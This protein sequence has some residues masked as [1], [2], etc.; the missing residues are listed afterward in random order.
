MSGFE[1]RNSDAESLKFRLR[2]WVVALVVLLMFGL[3]VFRLFTLQVVRHDAFAE[4]AESNRTAVVPIVPNRGQILDRNG[5]VLATNYS[6]YT[7]EITRSKVNDLEDTITQLSE[8]VDI[9]PRDRRKFKRLMEDSKRFE[10][11]PIR[12][13]LTDEEVARFAAQRWRFPGVDIKARFFRSYP[14]EDV[15][16]H[17]VGY[18]G[19]INQKEQEALEDS[20][21]AANYRGTEVIGK[22]GIEQSYEKQLHGTTGWEQLET[23]AGGFAVRRLN[24]RPAT[25][26]DSVVLSLDIGLQKLVEDLFGERRGALVAMDPR[27]GEVLAMVSKPGYDVNLFVDGIDQE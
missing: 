10:S 16:G 17:V 8:L 4:R 27:N 23:T 18:I 6:A 15:G 24:S 12:S 7:L 20:D 26:G 5:I 19:R 21:D 25:A 13:R 22:L 2:V 9:T 14:L 3:L 11:I 1:L